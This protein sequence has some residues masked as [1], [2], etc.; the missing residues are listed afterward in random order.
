M[1][2]R[3]QRMCELLDVEGFGKLPLETKK[4]AVTFVSMLPYRALIERPN[5]TINAKSIEFDW[6]WFSCE[7]EELLI[8]YSDF[9]AA[10]VTH[11][12]LKPDE[13]DLLQKKLDE[14]F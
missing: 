11:D 3:T 9:R 4:N 5:I 2:V 14:T 8:V 13:L 7:I 1:Q 6:P 12:L 10:P